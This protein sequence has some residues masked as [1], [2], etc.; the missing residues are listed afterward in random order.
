MRHVI[1]NVGHE[2]I[3]VLVDFLVIVMGRIE[4][5]FL[6]LA[7]NYYE[8]SSLVNHYAEC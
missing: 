7:N 8:V 2:N 5:I 4:N 6:N 3:T 1:Q